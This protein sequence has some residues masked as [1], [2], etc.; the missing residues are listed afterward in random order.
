MTGHIRVLHVDDEPGFVD[1]TAELLQRADA[2]IEVVS[3]T[4]ATDALDRLETSAVDAVVSD[5]DMP[6]ANGLELL[7]AVRDTHPDLP[8]ILY[9]GK[10]SEE[11]A[12]DAVSAGVTDYMQKERGTD[13]Y[14]VLANRIANS[15]AQSRSQRAADRTKQRLEELTENSAD[16]LWM[17]DD[18]WTDLLFISGY[19]DVYRRPVRA[20][21]ENPEDFLNA[22]YD[23][24]REFVE[25]QM[26]RLQ[27]GESVD[28]E[29]RIERGDDD[30][31]WVWVKAEPV[32]EGDEVVR[33]VGFTRD[34]TERK[35]RERELQDERSFI[36]QALDSLDDVFY[37]VDPD[38]GLR[39]WNARLADVTGYTDDELATCHVTE[40]FPDGEQQHIEDAIADALERGRAVVESNLVTAD[41]HHRPYEFRA[42]RFTDADGDVSGI[43]TI[44][45]EVTER[46]AREQAV[47][48]LHGAT[49]DLIAANSHQE[50]ADV[51]TNA[52]VELL[53]LPQT[54][55]HRYDDDVDALVPVSWA[56][57][58]CD[59]IGDP[60]A[61]GR[62]SLALQVFED[63]ETRVFED[64]QQRN[65]IHNQETPV[66][67]E[68]I[69]P[70]GEYGV[71]IVGSLEPSGFDDLDRQ[72]VEL[73]CENAAATLD[74]VRREEL[75]RERE[76]EL[77]EKNDQLEEFASVVSHDLRNP[78]N[79]AAGRIELAAEDTDSDHLE[80]ATAAVDRSQT[81]VEDLLALARD[82]QPATSATDVDLA[83]LATT[84][85]ETVETADATLSVDVDC[86]VRA[87]ESRLKQLFENLYRNSVEHGG[88]GVAVQVGRLDDG[89]YVADDGPGIPDGV[90]DRVFDP[91]FSTTQDG[92]GF[93]LDIVA[94]VADEHDWTVTATTADSGGARFEFG[95]VD[96]VD[97]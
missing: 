25:D 19:E 45:R 79:V 43:V 42:R 7:D 8:F 50:V 58:V 22:V 39:R 53:D 26:A 41:G 29:Y 95:N 49:R 64:L 91:G 28:V 70:I 94:Q 14:A 6:G 35:R 32:F 16:C 90:R 24:D 18:Q 27:T 82:D 89:F 78:L 40:F 80:A 54:G 44:G 85:W 33:V 74:R 72:L 88:G 3:E 15:V 61:L 56:D 66:R 59:V 65:D 1:L 96:A 46:S 17:F 77:T 76:R 37:V 51:L 73:L 60:P 5:Y 30:L 36:D 83:D 97:E 55:V 84:A 11:V 47:E 75:L 12:S 62:D 92:T 67:S 13:Q 87:T 63:G 10:G 69:A 57:A 48:A 71:A 68:L 93:G 2:R 38:G 81:L 34:V 23:D 52:A 21:R 4:N 20:L 9:T 86:A 31:G